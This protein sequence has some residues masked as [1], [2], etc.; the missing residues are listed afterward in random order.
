MLM[1]S[2]VRL[3]KRLSAEC[4]TGGH[5]KV[6]N[7]VM[8]SAFWTWEEEDWMLQLE[9]TRRERQKEWVFNGF[10]FVWIYMDVFHG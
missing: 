4:V 10:T 9:K 8:A 7:H 6:G 2:V 3:C 5:N 1:F